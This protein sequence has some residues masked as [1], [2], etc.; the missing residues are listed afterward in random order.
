MSTIQSVET[1]HCNAGWRNYHFVR[2]TT[3][4]GVV[5]WSEY[6]ENLGATGITT[7]I[8]DMADVVVGKSVMAIERIRAKLIPRVRQSYTGVGAMALG[9]IENALLD[10]KA[11]EL[12]VPCVDLLGGA[13]RDEIPVYWSHCGTYRINYPEYYDPVESLEDVRAL[14]EEVRDSQF[15]ALKTNIFDFRG[16]EPQ[17]WRPGFGGP[18][19]P[20]LTIEADQLAAQRDYLEALHE[21]AG[22]DVD[23]L[24]DLNY[25]MKPEGYI[26]LLRELADF[27]LFWVEIDMPDAKALADVRRASPH[28]IS[29]CE[30]LVP[31]ESFVS[32]FREQSMDVVIIDAL[33]NGIQQSTK[34]ASMADAHQY[35]VA[36][37][38]YYGHLAT[39]MN[40]HLAAAIPNLRIMETD[41]DR[42]PWDVDLFTTAPT[43][44]DGKLQLST[45]PGWGCEPDESALEE[46]PPGA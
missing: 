39:F 40:A 14:G 18:F 13:V 43:Y 25:N 24:L 19:H 15:T 31:H 7:I 42:L 38:N 35:H 30:A 32:F 21:G 8:E 44:R 16:D 20:S 26:R 22:P 29:S 41:I 23:I 34:I 6:D 3:T 1:R 12:G 9:A 10:A 17:G 37:H 33:W 4:E 46:H 28:P 27:D 45:E 11:K 5:G 36:P 2:V